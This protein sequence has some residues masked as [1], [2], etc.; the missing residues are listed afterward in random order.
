MNRLVWGHRGCR[1]AGNPPENSLAAFQCASDCGAGGIELDV[2]LTRD[3]LVV[4]FHDTSLERMTGATGDLSTLTLGEIKQLRLLTPDGRRSQEAIPTLDEVLDQFGRTSPQPPFSVNIEL[5]APRS[6]A[7]VAVIIKQRLTQ[8]WALEHFLVSSFDMDCLRQIAALI[9][10]LPIGTLFECSGDDLATRILETED[11]KP[12]TVNIPFASLTPSTLALIEAR[13]A[14]AVVWTPNETNP[15]RL[16]PLEREQLLKQLRERRFITITDYPAQ[17][18][19]LLK[20]NKARAT[21]TG[22]LAACLSYGE[23]DL[24]FRPTESGLESL[25]SPSE[26]KELEPFGFREAEL[27]APDGVHF[28]VWERPG[29]GNRPHFLL[30]HGNRAHWGDTGPGGPPRD[31]RARLKFIQELASTGAAVTAVTLRGFGRSRVTPS[32]K[33][34][35]L[36]ICAL[37]E[38]LLAAGCDPRKLAIV[39]ESM[40]TWAAVQAA[41]CLTRQ[42]RPPA[43][44]SL[45]NPFTRMA[46][47]GELFVSQ[48]PILRS[49][50]IGLSAAALD[51]HVLKN[52]FYTAQLLPE[53]SVETLLHIA[54]S[55]KDVV[56]HPSQS[57]KLAEI[58]QK[59]GLRVFRDTYPDAMHHNIPPVEFARRVITLGAQ[60]CWPDLHNQELTGD[61]LRPMIP[62]DLPA[63]LITSEV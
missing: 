11:L 31:R 42:N 56:V 27:A 20:P 45:Q 7:A 2:Q 26:Y 16:P 37:T 58:A 52:H 61:S 34:F 4:V 22:V 49:L 62:G 46:D 29:C 24:L 48:V 33:G 15:N 63:I 47:V 5:K 13:G 21:V 1:G 14:T 59:Q 38:Y 6:A 12:S 36:D 30:F 3:G 40:G 55:G 39:G 50:N 23:Q 25:K 32:E 54:T 53:L 10:G 44:V 28:N 17:L 51:R 35:A 18:L 41:A 19:A 60:Y 43:L 8:G 57:A 9:P